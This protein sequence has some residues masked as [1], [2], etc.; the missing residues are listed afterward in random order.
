[1]VWGLD[2]FF[3]ENCALSGS[4]P[5]DW[6]TKFASGFSGGHRDELMVGEEKRFARSANTPPFP[7]KL[8][9]DGKYGVLPLRQAQGHDDGVR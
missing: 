2:K 8:G 9:K 3:V 1:V 7:M 4:P 5:L 6:I